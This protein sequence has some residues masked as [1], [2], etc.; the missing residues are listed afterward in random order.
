MKNSDNNKFYKTTKRTKKKKNKVSKSKINEEV[1]FFTIISICYESLKLYFKNI[2]IFFK[3]LFWPIFGQLLGLI[4]IFSATYFYTINFQTN[5]AKF[6]ILENQN[7][8]FLFLLLFTLPGFL[9]FTKS[10]W[11]YLISIAAINSISVDVD[12]SG[13][14]KNI[15]SHYDIVFRRSKD[16]IILLL[17]IAFITFLGYLCFIIPGLIFSLLF[18]LTIQIFALDESKNI[19]SILKTSISIVSKHL[20]SIICILI[21]LFIVSYIII[22]KSVYFAVSYLK[23]DYYLST[24]I[25]AFIQTLP[26]KQFNLDSLEVSNHIFEMII[27]S[28]ACGFT[29]PIRDIALTL[30][31]RRYE[32]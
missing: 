23:L 27:T 2:D 16:Y 29:L 26:L 6:S 31:Y 10:F 25:E 28:I 32:K 4:F 24:P 22:P 7:I 1:K 18:C 20:F 17:I 5:L 14:I 9:I 21:F 30:F 3:I 11:D 12:T 15:Q 13:H 8:S 19:F